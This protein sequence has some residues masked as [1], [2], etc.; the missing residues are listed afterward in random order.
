MNKEGMNQL[1]P[2]LRQYMGIKGEYPDAILFFRMGDFYEMF[3]DDARTA[4]Q[5]LGITL[6][7]RGTLNGEKVP[8]C[9]I[10][11]HASKSYVARL[12]ESGW[13]VAICDQLEDPRASKG[14]VKRD[15]V[16][17]VTPGS[18]I[19]EDAL[20]DKNN[21]FMAAISANNEKYGL[22]H[23][24]LSTGEFRVTEL[25]T[26]GEFLDELSRIAPAEILI[27]EDEH[28]SRLKGL[29]E[30]RLEILKRD[31][32]DPMRAE[33]L[34][35]DQLG[36]RSL[37]GFGCQD[38]DQGVIAAG[39]LVYYLKETQKGSPEHIKEI[40]S[41]HTGDFMFLDGPTCAHLELLKTMRRQSEKG[42]LFHILDRTV[43]PMGSR[44]LKN[45]IVYPLI[46]V[47]KI[48]ARLGAVSCL[49]D[50][51]MLRDELREGLKEIYDLERLRGRIALAR[52]NARDLIALKSSI[53]RLPLVKR[54]LI[55]STSSLLSEKAAKMDTLD[56]IAGLIEEAIHDDPPVS[57]KEG[58][59]IKEG[60][61]QDLDDLIA[62]SRDG[63]SWITDFGLAEQKRTGI[64]SLKVGYN[65]VFG[66]YI[67]IS[68]ANLHNV[69]SDYIRKQTLANGERFITEALKIREEQVLG[70]EE[71]RIGLELEI[72][73]SIRGRIAHENQRIKDTA[74][75]VAEVDVF[76]SLA[77]S[78]EINNY[79]CPEVNEGTDIEI[80]DGRHPVIE[81]TVKEEDFVPN[82]IR[83]DSSHQQVQIITG[84][85]MAGKSTI[86]RQTALT[87]LMTQ[88]GSF[89]PASRATIGIVDRIFTRV[90]ASDDLAR[91][92]STF[93]VEMNETANILR[94]ATP[95]S[96]VI[97]DE[98]GR[99]TSTYDGLSIAWAVA[100]ALH[101]RDGKGVRTLFA[102]HYHELTELVS[103]KPRVKNF[104]IAVREWNN[105]VIFLRK[106]LPGGTSRSYGI[107]VARIAG[108][109]ET[110]LKRAKEILDNLEGI[111]LDGR[112]SRCSQHP[113][114]QKHEG[115]MVQ[116]N[117]F[118]PEEK[119]IS[120]WISGLALET[121]TPIE[122]LTELNNMQI[123]I[124]K[125]M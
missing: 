90:G 36:V 3:F 66:Y 87:V 88:T 107:Q 89:V 124:R 59:I 104:N 24:D 99:G 31:S 80:V 37:V 33:A 51:P 69:P 116:L 56:D 17:V 94:H 91:G 45:W 55:D 40:V 43:T 35:K 74:R 39:A 49:R 117:L 32:F 19:D 92:H 13:K 54:L 15:V 9:G 42:S 53:N 14:I 68:N 28:L 20:D 4:S 96:L 10:P 7:A 79:T 48:R 95:K 103:T 50:D 122:A 61:N 120:D 2:M 73:N 101:D 84:P 97:L 112:G 11:H 1:T 26:Q 44:L 67:E 47:E 81:L 63:K 119:R 62:L 93:M 78:A 121:M 98:I 100:E 110:V 75:I 60:Y 57:I 105:Q 71:K 29:A 58:G 27:P 12:V 109:P 16:R 34:L 52:A 76:A 65:R 108:L 6:T 77:E 18:I 114:Q 111:G 5:V 83:L 106:L 82:D 22:A 46:N 25:A 38:M 118:E 123:F 125:G 72:F 70:A 30:Y 64:S 102:T 85:N 23:V 21:L 115:G 86:L 113:L 41:Y 8:M